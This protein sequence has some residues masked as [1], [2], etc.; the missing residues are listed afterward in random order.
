M[1]IHPASEEFSLCRQD[2]ITF[3][4]LPHKLKFIVI[5][6]NIITGPGDHILSRCRDI[7]S[8]SGLNIG[9]YIGVCLEYAYRILLGVSLKCIN[10]QDNGKQ[11]LHLKRIE[12][13]KNYWPVKLNSNISKIRFQAT[14]IL[15]QRKK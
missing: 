2:K 4:F 13:V 14:S 11:L 8:R 9:P 5:C 7:G 12:K 1:V 10:S 15:L 6:P 3:H